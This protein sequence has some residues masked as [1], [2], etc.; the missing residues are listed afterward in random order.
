MKPS[1]G[2]RDCAMLAV[3][4]GRAQIGLVP[5]RHS[6]VEVSMLAKHRWY[7]IALVLIAI[8]SPA[9]DLQAAAAKVNSIDWHA[10]GSVPCAWIEPLARPDGS[11]DAETIVERLREYGFGCVALPIQS[12][13]PE[14]LKDFQNLAAAANAAAIDVWPVLIPPT[15]GGNSLPYGTDFVQW[16]KVLAQL[17]LRY[18]HL[19][20]ANIDDIFINTNVNVFMRR[21]L[22]AIYQAKQ[23]VNPR[24]QFIATL[25]DLNRGAA[26]RMAGCV[27]GVW[28]WWMNLER[29]AGLPSFLE[30]TQLAV[31][32]R[33]PVYAGVY[34]H[35]TSWHK[36]S[37]PT[38]HV[39][40]RTLTDACL[41]GDGAI[42]WNLSLEPS[43]PLLGVTRTFARGGSNKLA[44]K[45]GQ[46]PASEKPK[47]PWTN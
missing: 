30:N 44:G 25:Y 21:E 24:F 23:A 18:P 33:F 15:E 41:Y 35:S 11:L 29:A 12:A 27:D 1:Y 10:M 9:R 16:F 20:G 47:I 5:P 31:A 26:D 37:N 34:A 8:A 14:S 42:I 3:V 2:D 6:N 19:R 46:V 45:C 22:C 40:E 4:P 28:L 17:S 39:F 43:D 13:P 38:P 36:G 7:C 32:H